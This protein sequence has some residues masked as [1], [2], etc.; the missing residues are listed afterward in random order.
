ML[1]DTEATVEAGQGGGGG[2]GVWIIA[3]TPIEDHSGQA[4]VRHWMTIQSC[5]LGA[6]GKTVTVKVVVGGDVVV[7][8]L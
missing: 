4:P 7:G 3:W 1:G 6:W 2:G 5:V 8:G